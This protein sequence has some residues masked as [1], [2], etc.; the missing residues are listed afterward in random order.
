MSAVA[1]RRIGKTLALLGSLEDGE[2]LAAARALGRLLDG[3]GIDHHA[4]A[5][6]VTAELE[7]R[8]RPAFT[9]AGMGARAARKMMAHLARQPIA[10]VADRARLEWFR[11]RLL[12]ARDLDLSAQEVA[13]LDGLWRQANGAG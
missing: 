6:L 4:L 12:G 8:A 11:E 10:S 5:A 13:W 1:A 7:R 3:A 2:A 9:F